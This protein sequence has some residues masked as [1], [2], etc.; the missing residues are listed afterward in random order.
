M[1]RSALFRFEEKTMR[2][3][4][5]IVVGP[6]AKLELVRY[7]FIDLLINVLI[8]RFNGKVGYLILCFMIVSSQ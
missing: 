6:I 4:Q 7:L 1:V 5:W 8:I 2:K 3:L